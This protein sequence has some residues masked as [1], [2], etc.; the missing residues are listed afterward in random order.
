MRPRTVLRIARWETTKGVGGLDRGAVAVM[1]AAAAFV[2]AF[3]V[4]GQIGRAHV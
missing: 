1:L 2:V 4:V 3:G